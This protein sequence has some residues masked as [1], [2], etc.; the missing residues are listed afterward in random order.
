MERQLTVPPQKTAKWWLDLSEFLSASRKE[1][2]ICNFY[3][4]FS[5]HFNVDRY[6]DKNVWR[7]LIVL[8]FTLGFMVAEILV[9]ILTGIVTKTSRIVYDFYNIF[10]LKRFTCSSQWCISYALRWSG[11]HYWTDCSSRT[12]QRYKQFKIFVDNERG[13]FLTTNCK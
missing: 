10:Q 6:K 1:Q 7:I 11:S 5:F 4:N 3:L 9:G 13:I 8:T 12:S 2:K